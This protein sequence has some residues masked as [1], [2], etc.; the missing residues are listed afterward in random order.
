MNLL[1][2]IGLGVFGVW[3][4]KLFSNRNQVVERLE[5]EK[6]VEKAHLESLKEEQKTLKEKTIEKHKNLSEDGKVVF[7]EDYVKKD[8][9]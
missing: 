6:T 5:K 2:A 1:I 3:L 4:Y 8:S 9:E 7:W